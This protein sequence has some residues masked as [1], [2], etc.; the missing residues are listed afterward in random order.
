[1]LTPQAILDTVS[2][3]TRDKL[4]YYVRMRYV[5][6]KKVKRGKFDYVEFTKK[7]LLVIEKAFFYIS[8]YDTQPRTA[9]K[10]AWKEIR[11]PSLNFERK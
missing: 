4:S 5:R 11:Q 1:M 2:G 8:K 7:E 9:F 6:P 10:N 3:L